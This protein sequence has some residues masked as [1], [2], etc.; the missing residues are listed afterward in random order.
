MLLWPEYKVSWF[1]PRNGKVTDSGKEN[2]TGATIFNP[3][4]LKESGNDW[5]L[6]LEKI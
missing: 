1:D 2:N 4:G 6:I 5:V 3:P